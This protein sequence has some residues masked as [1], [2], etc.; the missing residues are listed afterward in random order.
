MQLQNVDGGGDGTRST[1]SGSRIGG[2]G[3]DQDWGVCYCCCCC[4]ICD[5]DDD[6][7]FSVTK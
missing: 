7:R 3:A 6:D 2:V 4:F 1:C 5:D